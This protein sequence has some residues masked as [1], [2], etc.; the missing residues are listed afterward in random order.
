MSIA[1]SVKA[2]NV[3][4]L[5]NTEVE[6][7]AIELSRFLAEG[8]ETE[9]VLKRVT[10]LPH[11]TFYLTEYPVKRVPQIEEIVGQ[12]AAQTKPID[13]NLEGYSLVS[14]FVFWNAKITPE[15]RALHYKVLDVL[16]PLRYRK[17]SYIPLTGLTKSQMEA[18]ERYGH[19]LSGP[20]FMPHITLTRMVREEEGKA[21]INSLPGENMSF[22]IN[23]IS[24]AVGGPNGT[25][26]DV[27]QR[28]PLAA[29]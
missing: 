1:E 7:K 8:F 13:I 24:L 17:E 29:E 20:E 25:C 28:F 27:I 9:F 18:F 4:T 16:N 21:A 12:I 10:L 23:N 11:L 14:G 22:T 5:P 2:L 26:S 19:V 3:L 6:A 15:L